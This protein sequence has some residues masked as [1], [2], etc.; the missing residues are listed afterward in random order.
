MVNYLFEVG[1]STG[2]GP[3]THLEIAAWCALT[4][5]ELE[6]WEVQALR[7]MSGAY[8]S[9]A[10]E[11]T[12][13]KRPAPAWVGESPSREVVAN[14]IESILTRMEEQDRKGR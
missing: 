11:A 13:P 14:T 1:P 7:R 5:R 9:E 3:V 8:L 6:P 12:D 4:G 10:T 2:E